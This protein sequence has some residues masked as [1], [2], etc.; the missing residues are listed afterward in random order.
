MENEDDL[1]RISY[2]GIERIAEHAAAQVCTKG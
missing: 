2:K 1:P